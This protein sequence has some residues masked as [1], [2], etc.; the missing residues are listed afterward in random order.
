[1]PIYGGAITVHRSYDDGNCSARVACRQELGLP[2]SVLSVSYEFTL[3][4]FYNV[5]T[6]MINNQLS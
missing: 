6:H 2:V 3:H 4:T 5:Y 1:M